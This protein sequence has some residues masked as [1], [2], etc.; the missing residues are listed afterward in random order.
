MHDSDD[1]WKLLQ[2]ELGLVPAEDP[3]ARAPRPAPPP[4]KPVAD[5]PPDL[6]SP[7]PAL[8]VPP[9]PRVP[10]PADEPLPTVR[11]EFAA[12]LAANAEP[13]TAEENVVEMGEAPEEIPEE[14]APPDDGKRKRRRRR[15]RGRKPDEAPA[16][17]GE[18]TQPVA[19]DAQGIP[20]PADQSDEEEDD[21]GAEDDDDDDDVEPIVLTDWNVPTWQELIGS[22]YRPER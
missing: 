5:V 9:P 14:P 4:P 11:V 3:A 8:E 1:P 6:P 7:S 10:E 15:R 16:I 21:A 20:E 13:P 12:D 18:A 19:A 2:Q 17:N 22:L